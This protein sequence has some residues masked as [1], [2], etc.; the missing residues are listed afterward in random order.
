[1]SVP[2]IPPAVHAPRQLAFWHETDPVTEA[3]LDRSRQEGCEGIVFTAGIR[4]GS[5]EII[6]V[7]PPRQPSAE[8]ISAVK[9][10]SLS[11][12]LHLKLRF[13]DDLRSARGQIGRLL[14][15]D[16]S[17]TSLCDYADLRC[18][19]S[20][21]ELI[22]ALHHRFPQAD[23]FLL[24]S[25]ID[26]CVFT[27][28]SLHHSRSYMR[29]FKDRYQYVPSA[30]GLAE[31]AT[32]RRD[33]YATWEDM[34][35]RLQS[36]VTQEIWAN[37]SAQVPVIHRYLNKPGQLSPNPFRIAL[38]TSNG[39]LMD[40]GNGQVAEALARSIRRYH[41]DAQVWLQV[42]GSQII[43]MDDPTEEHVVDV[44]VVWN[45]D[46]LA[47]LD[48][49]QRM[50]YD[51]SLAALMSCLQENH[52]NFSLIPPEVITTAEEPTESG[53]FRRKEAEFRCVIYP[54]ASILRQIDW[55]VLESFSLQ[56]GNLIFYGA[57]PQKTIEGRDLRHDFEQLNGTHN[58]HCLDCDAGSMLPDGIVALFREL[59]DGRIRWRG[60]DGGGG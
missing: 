44:A 7:A 42:S 48:P 22:R 10:T 50:R 45:W 18:Q 59:T 47:A 17:S 53:G 27:D 58:T 60:A 21:R 3:F 39:L 57:T 6:G 28:D 51:D 11:V 35:F 41:P 40:Q 24:D 14:S 15:G 55:E 19:S 20:D 16:S 33:Y 1:M 29:E 2:H 23:G 4:D 12:W 56:G 38:T 32:C 9:A 13:F 49:D 26:P 52:I 25:V 8:M 36:S 5:P 30:E 43:R 31:E 46:V 54:Y 34:L 37:Y